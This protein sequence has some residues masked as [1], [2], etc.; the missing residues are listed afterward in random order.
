MSDIAKWKLHGAVQTLRTELATWDLDQKDWQSAQG[1]SLISFHSDGTLNSQEI[2]NPDG[3]ITNSRWHYGDTHRLTESISWSNDGPIGRTVYLYDEARRHIKTTHLGHDGT[4]TDS[5]TCTY[6]GDGKR[7]KICFFGLH[8]G[9][10]FYGIEGTDHSY[11]APGATMMTTIYDE[12]NLPAKVLLQDANHAPLMDVIFVRDSAGKLLKE[13]S[14]IGGEP[15]YRD[16]LDKVPPKD[17]EGLVATLKKAFGET[18]SS[19]T[20]VYDAHGRLV[21]RMNRMGKV[22]ESR[23]TYHYDDHDNPI[24]ETTED[25]N[26]ETRDDENGTTQY[27][28]DRLTVQHNRLE[29]LYDAHGNWTER[30]VSIRP[31]P[32]PLFQRSNIERRVI[33][34]HAA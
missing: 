5:E 30:I 34:Y 25:R 29:Y 13:E 10:V 21:E 32:D 27:T 18:F 11:G 1:F 4:Q 3:S 28:S 12:K 24:E 31:E 19:T 20:Y 33:T 15:M 8:E 9:T 7:T 23:M 22:G 16:L 17:R 6:D 2:H 14:H 26:R